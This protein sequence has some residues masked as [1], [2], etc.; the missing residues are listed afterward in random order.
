MLLD[1]IAKNGKKTRFL[2]RCFKKFYILGL[3]SGGNVF[4]ETKNGLEELKYQSVL[5]E[6]ENNS[7]KKLKNENNT[8]IKIKP[9]N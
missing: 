1:S 6:K 2:Y 8:P 3:N 5:T 4:L 9:K 7:I